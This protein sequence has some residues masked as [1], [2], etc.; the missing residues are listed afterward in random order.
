MLMVDP[1]EDGTLTTHKYNFPG[2]F[3]VLLTVFNKEGCSKEIMQ[4]VQI[5]N[6]YDIIFPNAFSANADGIND[7]FQGEFTG[8]ASFNFK[9]Y[10]MWGA[11]IFSANHDFNNMPT[12]WGWNGNYSNGKPYSN[13]SFR[14]LFI[15]TTKDNKQITKTGEALLLR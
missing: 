4:S 8:I 1:E 12:N 9:I 10:D 11:L 13:T 3:D 15:G 5:G 14:Y 7:Y 2:V 6:G